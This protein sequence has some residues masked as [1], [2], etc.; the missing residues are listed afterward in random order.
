MDAV[1]KAIEAITYYL[2]LKV[3]FSFLT[4]S[5]ASG[6]LDPQPGIKPE[7]PAVKVQSPN[8]WT[9]SDV[10]QSVLLM[11]EIS[12]MTLSDGLAFIQSVASEPWCF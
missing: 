10:P 2:Q 4:V 9:T 11:Q 3:S 5:R 1:F 12:S 8:R 6:I 7:P